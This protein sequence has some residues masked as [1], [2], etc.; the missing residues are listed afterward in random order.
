MQKKKIKPK[1]KKKKKARKKRKKEIEIQ[2]KR[3]KKEL[4][5]KLGQHLGEVSPE[6]LPP[7]QLTT[8]GVDSSLINKYIIDREEADQ[9]ASRSIESEFRTSRRGDGN[10]E[11]CGDTKKFDTQRRYFLVANERLFCY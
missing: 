9:S 3:N 7:V 8:W 1:K 2:I 5:L 11:H 4:R 10:G 6:I